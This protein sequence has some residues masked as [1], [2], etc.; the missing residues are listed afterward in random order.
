MIQVLE[1]HT[2]QR[3]REIQKLIMMYKIVNALIAIDIQNYAAKSTRQTRSNQS[4]NYIPIGSRTSYYK[5]SFFPSVIPIWNG[6][7][8]QIKS[9]ESLDNFKTQLHGYYKP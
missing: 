5:A 9:T 2:L 3:R 4:F 6:L 7:P 1:W 8:D